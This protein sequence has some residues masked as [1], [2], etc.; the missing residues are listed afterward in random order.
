[1][2]REVIRVEPL[3]SYLEK[4]KASTSVVT[5]YGDTI[6][7]SGLLPSIRTPARSKKF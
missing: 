7:V 6:Y 3:S 4:L 2:E 1:M 5:R